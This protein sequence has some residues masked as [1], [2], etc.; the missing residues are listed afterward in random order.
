MPFLRVRL[1]MTMAVCRPNHTQC[2]FLVFVF[3][4]CF[5]VCE[6][7]HAL[8]YRLIL[9]ELIPVKYAE[10]ENIYCYFAETL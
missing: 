4:Q 8:P 3:R 2:Q 7:K 5:V 1:V 6:H 9:T 10:T